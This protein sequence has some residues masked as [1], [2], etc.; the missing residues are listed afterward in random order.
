MALERKAGPSEYERA[1]CVEVGRSAVRLD[2]EK[3]VNGGS[4][5][6]VSE[7]VHLYFQQNRESA[8]LP[9]FVHLRYFSQLME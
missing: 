7:V 5:L 4:A 3:N 9:D 2:T 1:R 6:K 8:Q